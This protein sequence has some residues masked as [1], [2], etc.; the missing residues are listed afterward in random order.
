MLTFSILLFCNTIYMKRFFI[1]L[2]LYTRFTYGFGSDLDSLLQRLKTAKEDTN[3]VK[4]LLNIENEYINI[5]PDSAFYYTEICNA[6]IGKLKDTAHIY[7][8]NLCYMEC[9][10][11][12][13]NFE[14]SIEYA[15]K[16]L[17]IA[18]KIK[19]QKRI[20]RSLSNI[21]TTYNRF[22][23]Y[24]QAV[25]YAIKTLKYSQ[26]TGDTLNISTRYA[27]IAW[28]YLGLRQY[29]K[30]IEYAEKGIIA[31]EKYNDIKG[32][33]KSLNNAGVAYDKINKI[34]KSL[35]LYEKKL[36]IALQHNIPYDA[37][38]S[39]VNLA[40][41]HYKRG[42]RKEL[43]KY[44]SSLNDM[45]A[46]NESLGDINLVGHI[47]GVNAM[48][49]MSLHQYSSAEK[50]L[51]A[52]LELVKDDS[53]ADAHLFLYEIYYKLKYC[54]NDIPGGEY[55]SY[56]VDSLNQKAFSDELAMYSM[57]LEAK[58][59]TQKK[60]N[61]ILQQQQQLK[62]RKNWNIILISS[63]FILAAL[64]FLLYRYLKQRNS[65]LE[66]EKIIQEQQIKRLE[67]EKQLE[68]T[69]AILN[70]QEEE[71][72][73]IAKD[74]HDGLG[75]LLSGVKYSLSNMKE[76]VLLSSEN[77]LSFERTID[78]LDSGIKELRR[79]SHNMMPE[80]LVKFG[81]D[82]ALKDYCNAITKTKALQVS[83]S[84]FG[85]EGFQANTNIS[86]TVYRVIQELINNTMKHAGAT[87]S[88]VQLSKDEHKLHITVEDNGKG[89]DTSK[90]YDFKGAGWTNIQN[91]VTYLKGKIDLDSSKENGTSVIIE[92][93]LS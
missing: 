70:G 73:R 59:E 87:E 45:L 55:Y 34:D 81:L 31:G 91:R 25:E 42:N 17:E 65:L 1:F 24:Y 33:L 15:F 13:Y 47:Y 44:V 66:K 54:M 41:Q 3:K 9:Y 32:L 16:N 46:K 62:K 43:I 36:T 5:N 92:I 88:I 22:G 23:R 50:N 51:N 63:I 12:K 71:R 40:I 60:E 77:A 26:Q 85:M 68:A 28:I 61:E 78:M 69:E 64:S 86:V 7:E 6:L 2:L 80:N 93:P 11:A 90:M 20:A 52:G 29:D 38:V 8:C 21:S 56:K 67:K 18:Q 35:P 75:G 4:L 49:D 74:L 83:Y 37:M 57:D 58:Y 39:L 48:K 76:N 14:K 30:S 19:N 53:N 89:F 79:V 72:S 84:S 10:Y 27:N 82:T